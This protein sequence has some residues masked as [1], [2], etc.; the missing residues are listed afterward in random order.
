MPN[1]KATRKDVPLY[2]VAEH[3]VGDLERP[4][5]VLNHDPDEEDWCEL[6]LDEP[7]IE[8]LDQAWGRALSELIA[9]IRETKMEV[10]GCRAGIEK[11]EQLPPKES[12]ELA[13]NPF[14][15]LNLDV[16][17]SGKRVLEF[18]DD[19][20][21]KIVRSHSNGAPAVL[22]TNLCANSGAEILKLWQGPKKPTAKARGKSACSDW[23]VSE[24]RA[25]PPKQTKKKYKDEAIARFGVGPDQFRTAWDEAAAIAPS[26]GWGM[27]GRPKKSSGQ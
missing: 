14:G 22:W 11:S 18:D 10:S 21:A 26:E 1:I 16:E 23:L 24:R 17:Y 19:F 5:Y 25:G 13:H 15:D 12:P 4:A 20:G 6:V 3:I 27:A 7:T 9:A 8:A 2:E